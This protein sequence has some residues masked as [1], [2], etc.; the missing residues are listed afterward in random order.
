MP[1]LRRTPAFLRRRGQLKICCSPRAS[2]T[3]PAQS[4]PFLLTAQDTPTPERFWIPV[5]TLCCRRWRPAQLRGH[6]VSSALPCISFRIRAKGAAGT[7]QR[8]K[9]PNPTSI[10][11][12][13]S[14]KL[15]CRS[16]HTTAKTDSAQQAWMNSRNLT[17]IASVAKHRQLVFSHPTLAAADLP[18]DA[19]FAA[20]LADSGS[21]LYTTNFPVHLKVLSLFVS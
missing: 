12:R 17:T 20:S 1:L 5:Q 3:W 19:I 14:L 21:S 9:F 7:F 15:K 8:G 18:N 10:R 2:V 16:A 11:K 6:S 4:Q 13:I